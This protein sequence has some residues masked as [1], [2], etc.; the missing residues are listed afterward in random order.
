MQLDIDLYEL[1][2]KKK[3][4]KIYSYYDD[5][6]PEDHENNLFE[7]FHLWNISNGRKRFASI[8]EERI[9]NRNN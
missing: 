4:P 2:I 1:L 7:C 9:P 5:E 3:Y 6:I 8:M